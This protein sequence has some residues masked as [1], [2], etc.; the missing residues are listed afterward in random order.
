[1]SAKWISLAKTLPRLTRAVVGYG[2]FGF[3]K[4][5]AEEV[6][7]G[8]IRNIH[9]AVLGKSLA[10]VFANAG[11]VWIKTGQILA[12]RSD[13]LP[14][15]MCYQLESLYSDQTP[16]PFRAVKRKIRGQKRLFK[17]IQ[18][19][20]RKPIGV[21]SIGQVHEAVLKDGGTVVIKVL[22]PKVQ[23]LVESDI[24]WFQMF[25]DSMF[26]LSKDKEL[27]QGLT[28]SLN[29]L[30]GAILEET[31][32]T[33]EKESIQRFHK[34]YLK[35]SKFFVPKVYEEY[36]NKEVLV[37]EKVK[38]LPLSEL[39]K[40]KGLSDKKRAELGE[41]LFKELLT[42]VLEDGDFHADPH[43]GN[44]FYLEDGRLAFIDL[45]LTGKFTS[46]DRK[47]LAQAVKAF[48]DQDSKRVIKALLEFGEHNESFDLEQFE[49]EIIEVVNQNKSEMRSYLSGSGKKGD[50][51]EN[52]VSK[53]FEISRRHGIYVPRDT[54]LLIKTLVTVEGVSRSLAPEFNL[55]KSAAPVVVGSLVPKWMKFPFRSR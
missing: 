9:Y 17:Q 15:E 27:K 51:L 29:D 54:T 49:E 44:V 4:Y 28:S 7:K 14:I 34:K 43:A 11:P 52:F 45:G 39:R 8:N 2:F 30:K 5:S 46:K 40:K 36:S 42:Q 35:S 23:Q 26:F 18:R 24:E 16:M 1:M 13:I 55:A 12:G 33:Q 37:M 3:P 22:R 25:I 31:N 53:L 47:R 21:G 20:D 32:L 48:F 10:R 38:G 50:T 19:I 41:R 6:L